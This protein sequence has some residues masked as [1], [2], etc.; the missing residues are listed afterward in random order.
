M[1]S[2]ITVSDCRL[3]KAVMLRRRMHPDTAVSSRRLWVP[4]FAGT[5]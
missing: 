3:T 5:K 2:M 4:V 1:P